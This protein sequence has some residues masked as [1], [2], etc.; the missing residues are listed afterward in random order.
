MFKVRSF[1]FI[2][3]SKQLLSSTFLKESGIWLKEKPL[4]AYQTASSNRRCTIGHVETNGENKLFD[5]G[6]LR[7]YFVKDVRCAEWQQRLFQ[8]IDAAPEEAVARCITKLIQP[9]VE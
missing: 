7:L 4:E 8:A 1:P 5:S 6:D 2:I 9:T 3:I